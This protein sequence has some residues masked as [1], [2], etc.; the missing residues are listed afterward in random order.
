MENLE[1]DKS[2]SKFRQFFK[3][4]GR[5]MDLLGNWYFEFWL[6]E[7]V[8]LSSPTSRRTSRS[9][10]R[11]CPRDYKPSIF[12]L[13]GTRP[14]G[15]K[16]LGFART[17]KFLSRYKILSPWIT[18]LRG[19]RFAKKDLRFSMRSFASRSGSWNFKI[20]SWKCSQARVIEQWL[21]FYTLPQNLSN[22]STK[23]TNWNVL[24]YLPSFAMH[25]N[26]L[27]LTQRRELLVHQSLK[28]QLIT[29]WLMRVS[30]N[31]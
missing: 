1:R 31:G 3:L 13:F 27:K 26:N 6:L 12:K 16:I 19:S 11:T 23:F 10:F 5:L 15:W 20:R 18:Q 22:F 25:E 8:R 28:H 9:K 29:K 2:I 21:K 14:E 30:S 17:M 4:A 7:F 24:I